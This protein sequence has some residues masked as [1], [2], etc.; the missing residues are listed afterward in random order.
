MHRMVPWEHLGSTTVPGD[1]RE[2]RLY[3][4]GDEFSI[5]I[6]NVELMNSRIYGSEDALAE[7]GCEHL[8]DRERAHVLVGGLGMGYTLAR[9][10]TR[11]GKQAIVVVAELVPAVVSWNRNEMAGLNGPAL[12]DGRVT[13]KEVDVSTLIRA[14]KKEF[15]AILLDVDNGPDALTSKSNGRLYSLTGLRAA[16]EALRPGG[17]LAVWSA[18]DDHA[19]TRRL[20]KAGFDAEARRVR[21]RGKAGGSRYIVWIARPAR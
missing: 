16:R 13:V 12:E 8:A 1:G 4:R 9:V 2:L 5:R 11:V 20:Q 3:R 7:L 19:F 17:V 6:G 18:G 14:A 10:L 15:D 21:A